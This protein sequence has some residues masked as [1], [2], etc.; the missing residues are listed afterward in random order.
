MAAMTTSTEPTESFQLTIE[1]AASY[2][3]DFVPAFF[4]QWAPVLCATA[5][6]ARGHKVLDVACGTGIVA[7]HAADI[8]GA[9]NVTGLDLNDAMLA[10]ARRVRPDIC[11]RQGDVA[12]LPFGDGSFDVVVCQMALMFFADRSAA[13]REMSRVATQGG[14]VAVLVPASLTEQPAYGPFIDL[15]AGHVGPEARS[16]LSTY[17]ACGDL[18][19]L[20]A[21]FAQAG[22]GASTSTELGAAR[23]DSVETA[24]ATE[25][26]ST[27]LGQSITPQMFERIL[28]DSRRV[29]AQYATTE[30]R[31]DIPFVSHVVAGRRP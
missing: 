12:A 19:Q 31:L 30:G 28:A 5:G 1:A 3:A 25:V 7:R 2:E 20:V 22:L 14:T 15:V 11:W 24:V 13:I 18:D 26:H 8:T 27:P 23:F 6:I 9:P 29:L 4:A 16:L 10:V 17:F 21:L